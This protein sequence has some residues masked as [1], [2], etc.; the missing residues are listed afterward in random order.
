MAK[1]AI[2]NDV[3]LNA[4]MMA[5]PLEEAGHEVI[6]EAE[7]VDFERI[8]RFGPQVVVLALWRQAHAIGHPIRSFA[9]D[10]LGAGHVRAVEDYPALGLLP[11]LIV[12]NSLKEEEVPCQGLSY[13]LFLTFPMD[14]NLYLPKVAELA[15]KVKSRRKISPY[16]CPK[17]GCG[18]RLTYAFEPIRDLFC[19]KCHTAVALVNHDRCI[20]KDDDG[21]DLP[22]SRQLLEPPAPG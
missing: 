7:P 22:C 2:I 18:S 3:A 17:P 10:V 21:Y 14:F 8:M 1:V 11:I 9:A 20:A 16:L 12:G 15:T 13:D 5:V 19:P 6:V 4:R